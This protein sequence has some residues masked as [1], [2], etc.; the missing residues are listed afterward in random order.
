VGR[1]KDTAN[2]NKWNPA[3]EAK[4]NEG[5]CFWVKAWEYYMNE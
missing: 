5:I 2:P 3:I 4:S 1:R